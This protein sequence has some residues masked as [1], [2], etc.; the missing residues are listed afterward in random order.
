[1]MIELKDESSKIPSLDTDRKK[2]Q[3]DIRFLFKPNTYTF[4]FKLLN[5]SKL[6][7]VV[8]NL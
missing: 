8:L 5:L 1:M 3:K 7:R 6:L 4:L 2:N